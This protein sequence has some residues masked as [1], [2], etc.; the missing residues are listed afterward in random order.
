VPQLHGFDLVVG[1]GSQAT[2]ARSLTT[3]DDIRVTW[4][5]RLAESA[6]CT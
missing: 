2:L 3:F 4:Q 1:S 5:C 6:R